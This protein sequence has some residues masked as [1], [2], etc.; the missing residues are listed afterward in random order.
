MRQFQRKLLLS[1]FLLS[2]C[3]TSLAAGNPIGILQVSPK[4][5]QLLANIVNAQ[6]ETVMRMN[7]VTG[8]IS[9]VPVVVGEPDSGKVNTAVA[10]TVLIEHFHVRCIL[11]NGYARSLNSTLRV[12][13]IVVGSHTAEFDVGEVYHREM[14]Y[15][16]TDALGTMQQNPL[17]FPAD[18]SLIHYAEKVVGTLHLSEID[19]MGALP[20][21][22]RIISGTILTGDV[23]INNQK[24]TEDLQHHFHADA[25]D[26]EAA[27]VAHVCWEEKTPFLSVTTISKSDS[28]GTS[29]N[30][31]TFH[32]IAAIN[33]IRLDEAIISKIGVN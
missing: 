1:L 14:I 27:A 28:N 12:G 17:F 22:P 24:D 29:I 11:F 4:P 6:T 9:G 26:M 23:Q 5:D 30:P 13:D 15:K 19:V 20:Y 31:D 16:S 25:M 32:K 10:S 18:H 33:I 3:L 21:S 2:Q 8:T 7:F